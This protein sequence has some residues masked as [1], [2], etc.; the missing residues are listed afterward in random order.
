MTQKKKGDA[1]E[2]AVAAIE[3]SI[4]GDRPTLAGGKLRIIPLIAP[5]GK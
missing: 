2:D 1:L 4:L 5:L 3:K